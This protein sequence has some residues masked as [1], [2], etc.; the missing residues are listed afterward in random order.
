[1]KVEVRNEPRSRAVLEIDVPEDDVAKAMDQ[2]YASLVRRVRI[3]GFRPGKAPRAILERHVGTDTLRE[4]ALRRLVPERYSAAVDEAGIEPIARPSIEIKEGPEGRGLHLTATVDV[5]PK[6]VL[7]D[8]RALHVAREHHPV[9]DED[10][11]HVLEDI[12]ARH[13]RLV[14]AGGEPARRG[15]FVLLT[16]AAAPKDLE[17]LQ[18]GKELLVEVGGGLLPA[19]LEA[20]LEGAR[21]GEDRS[22][23]AGGG[24]VT[25]HIV[26]VRRKDLPPLDDAFAQMVSDQPTMQALRERLRARAAQEREEQDAL[27]L[28][29]RVLDAVLAETQMDLPESLVEHELDHMMDELDAR[30]RSRGLS[31]ASYAKTRASRPAET[32]NIA[33]SEGEAAPASDAAVA[34]GTEEGTPPHRV[35][36]ENSPAVRSRPAASDD[37]AIRAIRAETQPAA[38]RRVRVRLL[39]ETVAEREGLTVSEEE[40]A[41]EVEKLADE[42]RQD[43]AKTRA[44]LSERGR[45]DG[46]RATILRRKAMNVL[47]EAVA[48]GTDAASQG[49]PGAGETAKSTGSTPTG[50]PPATPPGDDAPGGPAIM[51]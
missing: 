15:D 36:T 3:P 9:T 5:Y 48:G 22:V 47:M 49:A 32:G 34:A 28:R 51:P 31:L 44:W 45:Y 10:V 38:E 23:D 6:V 1:M 11:A 20:A 39:L 25:V 46:L 35:P 13:G 19:S 21:A 41:A 16:V 8:Y 30:L 40:M 18:P 37:E 33:P 7:P 24:T 42:L 17:R 27:D 2:A 50:E 12:R 14:S 29:R 26:D 4:E 43:A